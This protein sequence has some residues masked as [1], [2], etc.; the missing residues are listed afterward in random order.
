MSLT[1]ECKPTKE[2]CLLLEPTALVS[3]LSIYDWRRS[4][5]HHKM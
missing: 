3:Q 2:K 5:Q 1:G 4:I